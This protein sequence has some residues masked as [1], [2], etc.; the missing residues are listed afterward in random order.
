MCEFSHS[1]WD[2]G[3]KGSKV[4]LS[5]EQIQFIHSWSNCMTRNGESDLHQACG[6]FIRKKKKSEVYLYTIYSKFFFLAN[7]SIT[8]SQKKKMLGSKWRNIKIKESEGNGIDVSHLGW[9]IVSWTMAKNLVESLWLL[10]RRTPNMVSKSRWKIQTQV[11]M[12]M[13]CPRCLL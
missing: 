8:H 5:V 11:F 3:R 1:F 9:D 13:I 7:E 10:V 6:I 2:H 4:Y 12:P